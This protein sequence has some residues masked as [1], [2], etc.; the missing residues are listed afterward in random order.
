LTIWDLLEAS[1][2]GTFCASTF[3][4]S[5]MSCCNNSPHIQQR[6]SMAPEGQVPYHLL[7]YCHECWE[8]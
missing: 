3:G 8:K 1:T 2:S 5:T 7:Y 6:V 4:T